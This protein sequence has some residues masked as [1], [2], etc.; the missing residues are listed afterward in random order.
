MFSPAYLHAGNGRNCPVTSVLSFWGRLKHQELMLTFLKW[1][2]E[3]NSLKG[4]PPASWT[5]DNFRLADKNLRSDG[6]Y[7]LPHEVRMWHK[8]VVFNVH[9][10]QPP[11]LP[12]PCNHCHAGVDIPST[13]SFSVMKNVL[14]QSWNT[15]DLTSSP[16][17]DE[18]NRHHALIS[19]R[20]SKSDCCLLCLPQGHTYGSL[21]EDRSH[22]SLSIVNQISSLTITN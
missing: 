14:P 8:V 7:S 5:L 9:I 3:S 4:R 22:Y 6:I 11:K 16:L 1:N 13:L 20:R 2:R 21:N 15:L 17:I 12:Y 18:D 10:R 19:A